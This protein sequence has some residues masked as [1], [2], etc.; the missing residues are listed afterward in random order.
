MRHRF[1]RL[2][3]AGVATLAAVLLAV[4]PPAEAD[5][6]ELNIY[7]YRQEILIRPLLDAFTAQTG[8]TVN[9]V[10]GKADALLER[11][12]AEGSLS[13]ADLLLTADAGR[14]HRAHAA[15]VLQSVASETLAALVPPQYRHPEGYWFGLSVR[16]RPIIYAKGRVAPDALA[17][18]A[19]LAAE[20]WQER[21]CVRSSSNVY[22][23][24]L[25]AAMIA[26]QGAEATEVWARGLV[27]NFARKPS[28]GDR[29]QI[30]AVASGECDVAL[31]NHYYLARLATSDKE[32]DRAA[33][34][35]VGII[36]PNQ[37]STGV[38]V[39]VSGA[40]VVASAPNRENA[41]RFLEFLASDDA[42]RI[43]ADVVQEYPIRA[44][45]PPSAVVAAWGDFKADDLDLGLLGQH[46]AEALRVADRAG[47][48]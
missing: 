2:F 9:L 38:H 41:V 22:N 27:A 46:N 42:Q 17:R 47:W 10:S 8:I 7:S 45:I 25:L 5:D 6:G 43:Y 23:Q 24:S 1:C 48:R 21:V 4:S 16:A 12:K 35:A 37:A 40:G 3:A 33:A 11:L 29:D 39:N 36:W 32:A 31:A 14:L 18:Y 28:G 19:D 15:G 20:A 26:R 30:R 44:D 13:P 34:E